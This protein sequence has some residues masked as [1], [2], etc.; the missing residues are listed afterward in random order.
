MTTTEATLWRY[1]SRLAGMDG[2]NHWIPRLLVTDLPAAGR[3]GFNTCIPVSVSINEGRG[4]RSGMAKGC[5]DGN[6]PIRRPYR[7]SGEGRNPG[8][9][10]GRVNE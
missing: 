3:R 4:L 6:K 1:H 7:H 2:L 10:A 8:N 9:E 5:R